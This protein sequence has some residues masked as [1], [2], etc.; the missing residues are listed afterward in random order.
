MNISRQQPAFRQAV[1][2]VLSSPSGFPVRY[3][4]VNGAMRLCLA[5]KFIVLC[6]K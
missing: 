5:S 6:K 3:S 4:A 2:N 1:D